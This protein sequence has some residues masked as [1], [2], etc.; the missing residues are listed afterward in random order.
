MQ[1][2]NLYHE[3]ELYVQERAGEVD[4]AQRSG[5]VLSDTIVRGALA[6]IEKQPMAVLGSLDVDQNTW[7]SILFGQPGFMRS[8]EHT[9]HFDLSQT[10]Q[11]RLDP[12]W[13]NIQQNPQVGMLVVEFLTRRRLR[14]NGHITQISRH[15]LKLEVD[16]AYPNCP[17]YIQRRQYSLT[18]QGVSQETLSM[19]EGERLGRDQQSLIAA[20]DTFFVASSHPERGVDAS[21]RGGRPGFVKILDE[22]RLR[23]PDYRGNGMF[24]TLGNLAVNPSSGL[25]FLDFDRGRTLQLAGKAEIQWELEE[26]SAE[27]GGTYRYWDFVIDRWVEIDQAIPLRW[28]F[29]DYSPLNPR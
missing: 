13:S 23:I 1:E 6:F 25:A 18:S 5:K 7:A 28:E 19:R 26:A 29:L 24:N 14:V 10:S 20:A 21:H 16:Q 2:S 4:I 17:K 11:I 15:R 22:N 9:V 27:T 8:D 3:G 12:F